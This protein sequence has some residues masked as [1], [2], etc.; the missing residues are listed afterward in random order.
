MTKDLDSH[1][2]HTPASLADVLERDYFPMSGGKSLYLAE[3]EWRMVIAAL[4]S[5]SASDRRA[6]KYERAPEL[7]MRIRDGDDFA[8]D[9]WVRY[10]AVG[11]RPEDAA[12]DG[13]PL[14]IPDE[15]YILAPIADCIASAH[16]N[17][18]MPSP[19]FNPLVLD[20][21]RGR[22]W[23]LSYEINRLRA[24]KANAAPQETGEAHPPC[25]GATSPAESAAVCVVAT[26][27]PAELLRDFLADPEC[28][29]A[30]DIPD[31][32]W[33]PFCESL[34]AQVPAQNAEL[35]KKLRNAATWSH[36][37]QVELA[38]EAAAALSAQVPAVKE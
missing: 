12:P 8:G 2:R 29:V 35:V 23:E 13:T 30:D 21:V 26:P 33:I 11:H 6:I 9:A 7:D 36:K 1:E 20:M 25:T 31:E 16:R 27:S 17:S 10:T 14:T 3:H 24:L 34:R 18:G 28:H 5:E 15:A 37:H 19:E 4:R 22:I 32:I 38:N